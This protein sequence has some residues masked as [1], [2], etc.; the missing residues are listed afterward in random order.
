M[1]LDL[2]PEQQDFQKTVREF[3][4]D[5]IRPNAERWDHEHE[6]PMEAVKQMGDLGLFGLPFPEEY[7]G[8]GADFLTLCLAIEELARVDSSLAITLEAAVGLGAMPVYRFGNE[9]QKQRWLPTLAS[10]EALAGFGLT[11]PGGGSD[12]GATRSTGKLQDGEWVINGSKS[13]ITNSGTPITSFVTVTALTGEAGAREISAI[14]VPTGTPGFEVGKSYRKMGWWHSDT[15]ELSFND[16]KVPEENLLGDRGEGFRNFLK[17]LD[18]GR[19][20]IAALSVGLAQGC[21]DECL[22]YAKEREAFGRPIGSFQGLQFMISDMAT[23]VEL[24]RQAYYRAAWLAEIGR[25][26]KK[27]AAMAKLYA[28]KIAVDV[29]RDAVQVHGGY[30]YIEEF[31][32][33]RHYRD[34]KILEIGE[35]TSEVMRILI[36]R[37]LGLPES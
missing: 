17:I 21:L 35:G 31:P 32:V 16:C 5:A 26:Y 19:I 37:E 34:A 14:I 9:E 27:E 23:K 33:C 6:L 11:E 22:K 8:S 2:S 13:F 15:H 7:G 18:D 28:S 24:A 25:P 10:G 3:V 29:A 36:A 20:A 12:A 4:D 30:G 1:D